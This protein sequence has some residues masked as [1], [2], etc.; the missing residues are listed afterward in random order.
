MSPGDPQVSRALANLSRMTVGR[1]VNQVVLVITAVVLPR[2]FGTEEFGR[3]AALLAI[4]VILEAVASGGFHMAEIRFLA[5]VWHEGRTDEAVALGSSIWTVRLVLSIAAGGVALVWVATSPA[6]G[7]GALLIGAL[8]LVVVSRS[9]LEATRQLFLSLDRVGHMVGFETARTVAI[10]VCAAAAFEVGG[11]T[12]VFV[13]LAVVMSVLAGLAARR[14]RSIAPFSVFRF[15]WCVVRPVVRFSAVTMVGVVAWIVQAHLPVYLVA[16]QASLA[17]AAV[18]GITVQVYVMAQA[19]LIAPWSAV[20]PI[21]AEIDSSGDRNRLREWGGVMVRWG[22]ALSVAAALCWAFVGDVVLAVLPDG[23][24][25]V[26]QSGT[27]V[28]VAVALLGAAV[29]LNTIL[30]VGGRSAAGSAATVVFGLVTVVGTLIVLGVVDGAMAP[31]IAWVYLAA[32]AV[33]FG[34][35]Y[36]ALV[37]VRGMWMPLRRTMLLLAPAAVT[38][39]VVGWGAPVGVRALCLVGTLVVYGLVAMGSGLLPRR[40]V[41]RILERVRGGHG[42]AAQAGIAVAD[43]SR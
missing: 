5:P 14:L 32:S 37:V 4:V 25:V 8:A 17:D 3:Y 39:P 26:H 33:Y 31:A 2:L 12:G 34:W 19:L 38:W 22:T 30:Y 41:G 43:G 24:A 18:V 10:L 28:L 29:S 9:A 42:G 23:F 40:E 27:I 35:T 13:V 21:L 6:L 15:R 11:L 20:H 16:R 36:A 1:A 7:T